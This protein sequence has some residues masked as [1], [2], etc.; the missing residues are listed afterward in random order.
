MTIIRESHW[1]TIISRFL[2][3]FHDFPVKDNYFKISTK[4]TKCRGKWISGFRET[5]GKEEM[6]GNSHCKQEISLKIHVLS[7]K[8]VWIFHFVSS[9]KKYKTAS[10]NLKELQLHKDVTI[11]SRGLTHPSAPLWSVIWEARAFNLSNQQNLKH[12]CT[13]CVN[14]CSSRRYEARPGRKQT[15]FQKAYQDQIK[16]SSTLTQ[17]LNIKNLFQEN[18]RRCL[19]R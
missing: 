1:R 17:Q 13:S 2:P 12:S 6:I 4:V 3:R 10:V 7:V 19:Q 11:F 15:F 16:H 9:I 8:F 18:N 5:L 14:T